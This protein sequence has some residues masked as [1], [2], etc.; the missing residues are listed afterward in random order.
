MRD[1]FS[2]FGSVRRVTLKADRGI[3]FIAY[4]RRVDAERAKSSQDNAQFGNRTLKIRWAKSDQHRD[5]TVDPETGLMTFGGGGDSGPPITTTAAGFASS[6]SSVSS[7]PHKPYQRSGHPHQHGIP[8]GL[9]PQ[10]ESSFAD[11]YD[12]P[13]NNSNNGGARDR[14]SHD[15]YYQEQ[16]HEEDYA[17]GKRRFEGDHPQAPKRRFDED[18]GLQSM[19]TWSGRN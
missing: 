14:P 1:M 16:E 12:V 9:R 5:G 18:D 8:R 6:S 15:A 17:K 13:H 4:H 3:A 19:T 11:G 10:V 7:P 2:S